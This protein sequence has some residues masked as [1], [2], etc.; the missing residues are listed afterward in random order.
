MY[1]LRECYVTST[2]SLATKWTSA[3]AIVSRM[4]CACP[5]THTG[6]LS[7]SPYL[8]C[9]T[10]FLFIYRQ[11]QLCQPIASYMSYA[12]IQHLYFNTDN[13]LLAAGYKHNNVQV[14]TEF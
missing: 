12:A 10:L 2:H 7:F 8:L 6:V 5:D 4:Q 14:L 11:Q 3:L 9:V 1:V 13:V